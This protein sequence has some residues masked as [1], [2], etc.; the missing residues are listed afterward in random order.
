[1]ATFERSI[2]FRQPSKDFASS[3][4]SASSRA[5]WSRRSPSSMPV[6][7]LSGLA[8]LADIRAAKSHVRFTPESG[9]VRCS[10][11]CPLWAKSGH[12]PYRSWHATTLETEPFVCQVTVGH[13]LEEDIENGLFSRIVRT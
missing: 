1:M 8:P 2:A 11:G 13:N 6:A 10:L 4:I 5:I 12:L 3:S 7:F 9:H